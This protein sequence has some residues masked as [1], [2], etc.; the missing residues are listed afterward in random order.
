MTAPPPSPK[1]PST[2]KAPLLRTAIPFAIACLG[3]FTPHV[4]AADSR[5]WLK[6]RPEGQG[7]SSRK[8]DLL[9]SGD[10]DGNGHSPVATHGVV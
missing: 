9:F 2:K 4:G 3:I 6:S 8:L 1:F 7:V 5:T 10:G